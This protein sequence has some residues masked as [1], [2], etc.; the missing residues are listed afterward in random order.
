MNVSFLT[1]VRILLIGLQFFTVAYAQSC[2]SSITGTAVPAFASLD[3]QILA[4]MQQSSVKGGALSITYNGRLIHSRGY[5]CADTASNTAVR[6]DALMRVASVSKLFTAISVLE[7]F[8]QGKLSLDDKVF[9]PSGILSSFT[10]IP[11][12]SINPDLLTITVRHLLEHAGGWDRATTQRFNGVPYNEPIDGLLEAAPLALGNPPP[13]STSD[14]IRVMLSQ[15]VQHAPGTFFAYSNFGYA[16]LGRVVEKISGIG[17]EQFVEQNIL[18]PLGIGRQKLAATLMSDTANGEVTYYDAP[19]APLV[20]S[21]FSPATQVPRPYGGKLMEDLD[22]AGGWVANA[23][24]L[25]KFLDGVDGRRTGTPAL[26]NAA[27]L[28]QIVINPHLAGEPLQSYYGL[29]FLITPV[30][31]GNRWTKG[32]DFPGTAATVVHTPI[33]YSFAL[34]FNGNPAYDPNND[35]AGSFEGSLGSMVLTAVNQLG[36]AAP[37]GDQYANT[38]SSLL[39]P[40][41]NSIVQGATFQ[42]G[43]VSGSWATI[44]GQNLATANRIWWGNEFNGANLPAEI[45]HVRVR[46][47]GKAASVYYVS[48]T[49]LNVQAPTD[50]TMGPVS[51][52]V[53]RDGATSPAFQATLMSAAPGFFTYAS[54]GKQYLSAIHLNGAVIGDIAGT[55]P[56]ASGEVVELYATGLGSSIGGVIPSAPIALT[57]LPVVTIGGVQAAVSYAGLVSPGLFQIN[58]TIPKVGAGPQLVTISVGGATSIAGPVI[59]VTSN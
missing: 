37:S 20:P 59:A 33:G 43:I 41:I 18:K 32:G 16:V 4:A 21:V 11:G 36:T 53:I 39:T 9:G 6:P 55:L 40:A 7:L 45:D 26:L 3:Q 25:C 54:G 51:V 2:L 46:I 19:D 49:Q 10:P 1:I 47:N 28:A 48:P 42:P 38:D 44:T 31:A 8:Q 35:N 27:S 22:S 50:S 17:Y 58:A 24:D 29:G 52:Q 13:G 5:G 15:P 14:V 30:N 12:K 57:P 56:A 23:V 34:V